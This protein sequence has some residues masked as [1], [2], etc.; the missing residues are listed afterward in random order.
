M[1]RRIPDLGLDRLAV[2]LDAPGCELDADGGLAVEV[3][4]IAGESREEV[5]FADAAVA[6]EDN[7]E[8]ELSH[9]LAGR[10]NH[11]LLVLF[12]TSYSSF[13][14]VAVSAAG[15]ACLAS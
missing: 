9:P 11:D 2:D 4:L 5:G 10:P 3:E 12:H 1:T 6:Y 14:M 7:L 8:E 15:E 13:A